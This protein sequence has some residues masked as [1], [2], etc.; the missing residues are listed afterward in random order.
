MSA[1]KIWLCYLSVVLWQLP[2]KAQ[3]IERK[4]FHNYG[5]S[6]EIPSKWEFAT[7]NFALTNTFFL[8]YPLSDKQ[9]PLALFEAIGMTIT[10]DEAWQNLL[11]QQLKFLAQQSDNYAL[12][13]DANRFVPNLYLPYQFISFKTKAHKGTPASQTNILFIRK[14]R[15]I[16]ILKASSTIE[17]WS[18]YSPSFERIFSSFRPE[19][20]HYL[21]RALGYQI[22]IPPQ[23]SF[24]VSEN[25][26][27][28]EIFSAI[29]N[30]ITGIL[31]FMV[32]PNSEQNLSDYVAKEAL[33]TII[34][35]NN[36]KD[37]PIEQSNVANMQ[38]SHFAYYAPQDDNSK[39][40][41][42]K[43]C[44]FQH[45]DMVMLFSLSCQT[46]EKLRYERLLQQMLEQLEW[47]NH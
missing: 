30:P 37:I 33:E 3:N 29:E 31:R 20:T 45:N 21:N 46:A 16:F 26:E 4:Y 32:L 18:T 19:N 38:L 24:T 36:G 7:K 47:K 9:E 1:K 43:N 8:S 35:Y 28:I 23:Y 22:T 40:L 42:V 5:F 34:T 13:L 2:I 44:Y 14:N 15:D 12:L 17:Q 39:G 27:S 6:I 25:E 41:Y 11:E 10:N